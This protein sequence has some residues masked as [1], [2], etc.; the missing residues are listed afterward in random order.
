MVL[1]LIDTFPCLL[2]V[3]LQELSTWWM[4]LFC[5]HPFYTWTKPVTFEAA[6]DRN[7]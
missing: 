4:G 1:I 2:C 6:C 7:P 5:V 3:K